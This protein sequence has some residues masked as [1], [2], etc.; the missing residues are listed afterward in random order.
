M[1]DST[2]FWQGGTGGRGQEQAGVGMS[3]VIFTLEGRVLYNHALKE[4]LRSALYTSREC[5]MGKL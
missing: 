1:G 4:A 2:V 5:N 3:Y